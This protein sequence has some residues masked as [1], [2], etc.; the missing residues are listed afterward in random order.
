MN[1]ETDD[2]LVERLSHQLIPDPT[3]YA[4]VG[5]AIEVH[6]HLGPGYSELVYENALVHELEL[7]LRVFVSSCLRV[8]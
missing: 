7:F 1:D 4:V 8:A 5:A 2:V 6:R 3:S